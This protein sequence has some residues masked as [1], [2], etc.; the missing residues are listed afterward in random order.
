MI[1][2]LASDDVQHCSVSMHKGWRPDSPLVCAGV[3]SVTWVELC[4]FHGPCR[5]EKDQDE[6]ELCLLQTAVPPKVTVCPASPVPYP[7]IQGLNLPPVH[8]V[9]Q[10]Q[11]W[12]HSALIYACCSAVQQCLFKNY[13]HFH[14]FSSLLEKF[15]LASLPVGE[16]AF[17]GL[18]TLGWWKCEIAEGTV[19]PLAFNFLLL[20]LL[21][22]SLSSNL[23]Q[24]LTAFCLPAP[25]IPFVLRKNS[26]IKFPTTQSEFL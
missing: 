23:F 5:Q 11:S 17:Y 1:T 3:T 26:L 4:C 22:F 15:E 10:P 20:F 14:H 8:G 24:L 12:W 2:E 16:K 18:L 6:K 25:F 9:R 13:F 7:K 19:H 21:H